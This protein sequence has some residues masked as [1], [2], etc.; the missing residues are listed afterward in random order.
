MLSLLQEELERERDEAQKQVQDARERVEVSVQC[1]RT[2]PFLLPSNVVMID[3]I[4]GM[5]F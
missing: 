4:Q 3:W 5:I 2:F 1:D